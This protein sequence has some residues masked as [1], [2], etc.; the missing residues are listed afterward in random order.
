MD[1]KICCEW[2][3]IMPTYL[4]TPALNHNTLLPNVLSTVYL[5][6]LSLLLNF[7]SQIVK[8]LFLTA[9]WWILFFNFLS[10][11]ISSCFLLYKLY[12]HTLLPYWVDLLFQV[13]IQT[14]NYHA[15]W[16]P[17]FPDSIGS[18]MLFITIMGFSSF[19]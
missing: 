2:V 15:R 17:L 6:L 19:F 12:R 14:L 9:L 1:S 8:G 3:F 7:F 11:S 5:K 16:L 4:A 18:Y 13:M 10:I